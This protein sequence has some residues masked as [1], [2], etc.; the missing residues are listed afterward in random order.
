[1]EFYQDII[2]LPDIQVITTEI[3]GQDI[4]TLILWYYNQIK[5]DDR[6][7]LSDNDF[8]IMKD[9]PETYEAI[10]SSIA[11]IH[12]EIMGYPYYLPSKGAIIDPTEEKESKQNEVMDDETYHKNLLNQ[13]NEVKSKAWIYCQK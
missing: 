2:W 4:S 11:P 13:L 6:D 3:Y 5:L 7:L 9:V 1:M 10:A 12:K 8:F